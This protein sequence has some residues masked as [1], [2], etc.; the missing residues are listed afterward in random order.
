MQQGYSL[1]WCPEVTTTTCWE[2]L[3]L[4]EVAAE[5]EWNSQQAWQQCSGFF[6]VGEQR[7]S[8]LTSVPQDIIGSTRP[9]AEHG[10]E[11]GQPDCFIIGTPG[12]HSPRADAKDQVARVWAQRCQKPFLDEQGRGSRA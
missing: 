3:F 11:D 6:G 10:R 2:P 7:V 4:K 9:V 5:F 12:Q 8:T 1:C